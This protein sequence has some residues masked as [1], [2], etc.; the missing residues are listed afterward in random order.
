MKKFTQPTSV[1]EFFRARDANPFIF[2]F[3]PDGN[4]KVPATAELPEKIIPLPLYRPAKEDEI[5]TIW[6]ERDQS[7]NDIYKEIELKKKDLYEAL[8]LY[9]TGAGT[10]KQVVDANNQVGIE[11]ARLTQK[12]SAQR[13]IDVLEN[14]EVRSIDFENPYETRKLGFPVFVWKDFKISP[15]DLV[16]EMTDLEQAAQRASDEGAKT[17]FIASE[18]NGLGVHS[19]V[20]IQITD[21]RYFTPFQAIL[22]QISKTSD[23]VDMM[24]SILGTRSERTL[25]NLT[26]DWSEDRYKPEVLDAVVDAYAEQHPKFRDE[27]LKSGD[28]PIVYAN[29]LDQFLSAGLSADDPQ[30]VNQRAWKGYNLWGE[31]LM[32]GRTRIRQKSVTTA[33]G[34]GVG[35]GEGVVKMASITQDQQQKARTAAIIGTRKFKK[36]DLQRRSGPPPPPRPIG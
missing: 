24:K 18:E 7:F 23:E 15:Q 32:R 14:P 26:K 6:T 28:Q 16:K 10:A 9:K 30:I 29:P 31:A 19:P 21:V 36:S 3:T 8:A 34:E 27:L 11:E 33:P 5:A 2:T 25:R 12:R 13:Y 1:N 35:I 20:E 22:G 17:Y 4:C